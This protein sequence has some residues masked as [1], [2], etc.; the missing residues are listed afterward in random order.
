MLLVAF[1]STVASYVFTEIFKRAVDKK[2]LK[3]KEIESFVEDY[4]RRYHLAGHHRLLGTKSSRFW[5]FL[6]C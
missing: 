3:K 5:G 4:L 1:F 6:E 2:S